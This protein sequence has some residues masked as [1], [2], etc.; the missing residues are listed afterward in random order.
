MWQKENDGN[1]FRGF[2][3]EAPFFFLRIVIY[4]CVGHST[5]KRDEK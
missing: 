2:A 1:F 5:I 3:A 4:L